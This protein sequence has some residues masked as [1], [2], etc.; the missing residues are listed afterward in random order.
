MA[1]DS[2]GQAGSEIDD[3]YE[4]ALT[5]GFVPP[6]GRDKFIESFDCL[7]DSLKHSRERGKD[8]LAFNNANFVEKYLSGRFSVALYFES[9]YSTHHHHSTNSPVTDLGGAVGHSIV[10]VVDGFNSGYSLGDQDRDK[11]SMFVGIVELPQGPK[12]LVPSFV[13]SYF[14]EDEFPDLRNGDFYSSVPS[15]AF[16][17]TGNKFRLGAKGSFKFL[18]SFAHREGKSSVFPMQYFANREI[19]GAPHVVNGVADRQQ[20]SGGQRGNRTN[21]EGFSD[22]LHAFEFVLYPDRAEIRLKEILPNHMRLTDVLIG[23]S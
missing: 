15:L 16:C 12:H 20:E 6:G 8:R 19:K 23:P 4:L 18:P 1:H 5:C 13:R 7:V 10:V 3:A 17:P 14:I 22:F 9:S 2:T 11:Q 21:H